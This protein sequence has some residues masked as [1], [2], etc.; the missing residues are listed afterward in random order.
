MGFASTQLSGLSKFRE[1]TGNR[2]HSSNKQSAG[3]PYNNFIIDLV[4]VLEAILTSRQP[5]EKLQCL[6]E[7]Q[8]QIIFRKTAVL[9]KK[10][11]KHE[12]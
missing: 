6:Y 10:K 2:V 1:T 9:K 5:R 12:L 4:T 11:K 8:C 7:D 3:T